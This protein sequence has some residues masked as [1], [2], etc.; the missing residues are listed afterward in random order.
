MTICTSLLSRRSSVKCLAW[1]AKGS[2][3]EAEVE[4]ADASVSAAVV[5]LDALIRGQRM[6]A[7]ENDK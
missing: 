7:R 3:F 1:R 5:C 2:G 6:P 4:V